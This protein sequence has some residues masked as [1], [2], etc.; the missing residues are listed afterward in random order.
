MSVGT[1]LLDRE[2]IPLNT[3]FGIEMTDLNQLAILVFDSVENVVKALGQKSPIVRWEKNIYARQIRLAAENSYIVLKLCGHSWTVVFE[4]YFGGK[5]YRKIADLDACLFSEILKTKAIFYEV[6]DTD[7][8]LGYYFYERGEL[9][10]R[11]F[12]GE[13]F[14]RWE[15]G[16]F[17]DP[18]PEAY[19]E[20]YPGDYRFYS[21]HR[22]LS[23]EYIF[24]HNFEIVENFLVEQNCYVPSIYWDN[25]VPVDEPV[26]FKVD[27]LKATDIERIDY[28]VLESQTETN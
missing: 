10:E 23:E 13:S 9:I 19:E 12:Y 6:S 21:K 5:Y 26:I 20:D 24:S 7:Y 8:C 14:I 15:N 11:F 4:E 18:P 27:D 25:Q 1:F 17:R 16:V 3:R 28:I 2:D 22:E